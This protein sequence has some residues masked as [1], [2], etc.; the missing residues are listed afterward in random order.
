SIE[1][2][3]CSR[4]EPPVLWEQKAEI[5]VFHLMIPFHKEYA[6]NDSDG[7][8]VETHG[9]QYNACAVMQQRKG[10]RYEYF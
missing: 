7:G 8:A 3:E 5:P 9:F 2:V 10:T 1:T 6:I 4:A